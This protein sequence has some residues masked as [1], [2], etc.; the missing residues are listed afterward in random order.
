MGVPAPEQQNWIIEPL[1]AAGLD[2]EQ[3]RVLVFRLAFE[4]I[5][6]ADGSVACIDDVVRDQP[7]EIQAAWWHAI[8]RMLA[9][10]GRTSS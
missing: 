10:D 2:L 9:T 6:D 7:P 4:A 8:G 5:I 1:V 3:I